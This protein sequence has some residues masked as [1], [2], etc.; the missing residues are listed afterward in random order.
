MVETA[1]YS[2]WLHH[3]RF[4]LYYARWQWGEVDMV[5]RDDKKFQPQW[6]VDIKWSN[7]YVNHLKNLKS[8]IQFLR[9]NA[10][11]TALV[12]TTDQEGTE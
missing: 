11:K 1:I 7:Q 9:D 8:L 12:T 5:K 6:V 2:Q 4:I 10:M 3:V